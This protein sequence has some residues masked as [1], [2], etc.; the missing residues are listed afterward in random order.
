MINVQAA[1]STFTTAQL[2]TAKILAAFK[3]GKAEHNFMGHDYTCDGKQL[4]GASGICNAFEQIRQV[5]GASISV[6]SQE[7]V[8]AG[9]FYT[10]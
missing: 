4:A 8:T 6:A 7:F 1:L 3:T 10:P 2:T 9:S 5:K